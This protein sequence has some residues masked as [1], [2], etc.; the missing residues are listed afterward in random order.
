MRVKQKVQLSPRQHVAVLPAVQ[1]GAALLVSLLILLV[2]SLVGLAAMRG[3]LLQN[4]MSANTTQDTMAFQAADSA[5][6][7]FMLAANTGSPAMP[8]FVS[9]TVMTTPRAYTPT[10]RLALSN[11]ANAA[12]WTRCVDQNGNLALTCGA[13]DGEASRAG[14]ISARVSVGYFPPQPGIPTEVCPPGSQLDQKAK[15]KCHI[16]QIVGTATVGDAPRPAST[17]TLAV[18]MGAAGI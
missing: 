6:G 12:A 11:L 17:V 8:A 4:L 10:A 2:L 5:V 16:F 9:T 15:I 14:Q 3:G 13:F 18:H 1:G 7:A